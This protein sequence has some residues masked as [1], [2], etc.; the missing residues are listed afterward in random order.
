MGKAMIVIP[1]LI[2]VILLALMWYFKPPYVG[3]KD[4]TTGKRYLVW[5]RALISDLVLTIAA[6]VVIFMFAPEVMT[7]F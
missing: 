3:A 5:K 2:F 7:M 6:V 1:T 4:K